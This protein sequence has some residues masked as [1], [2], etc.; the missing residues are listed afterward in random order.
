MK[1]TNVVKVKDIFTVGGVSIGGGESASRGGLHPGESAARG[2][3]IQGVLHQGGCIQGVCI[4]V[5][6]GLDPGG[7]ASS[8][9]EGICIQG[10]LG[11]PPPIGY[12]GIR[13]TSGRYASYWNAFKFFK[14]LNLNSDHTLPPRH[15]NSAPTF[16]NSSFTAELC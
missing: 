8:G 2:V 15:S 4:W 13:Q 7:S 9:C 16:K 12:Y 14:I 10:R 5:P 3:C 11:R 6:G 1:E